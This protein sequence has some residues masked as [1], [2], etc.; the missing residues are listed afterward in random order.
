VEIGVAVITF[1][2]FAKVAVDVIGGGVKV[3]VDVT[4]GRV[5]VA[6]TGLGYAVGVVLR[7]QLTSTSSAMDKY[8]KRRILPPLLYWSHCIKKASSL[9]EG[10]FAE[11]I[12]S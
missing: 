6:V 10:L 11:S 1:H 7:A 5:K 12:F 8:F 4:G 2:D 3:A 9:R